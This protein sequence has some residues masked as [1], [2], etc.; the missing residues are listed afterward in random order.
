MR[1]LK[2][3]W[4][5]QTG[6]VLAGLF[7]AASTGLGALVLDSPTEIA[8]AGIGTFLVVASGYLV[9]DW[10][11]SRPRR[12]LDRAAAPVPVEP[13]TP[14]V[15]N[16]AVTA[17]RVEV[18]A[19]VAP[20]AEPPPPI[21]ASP[22]DEVV[23]DVAVLFIHGLSSSTETWAAFERLIGQ[24]RDLRSLDLIQFGY[25]TGVSTFRP[26]TRIPDLDTIAARLRT[27]FENLEG[28][29]RAVVIVTHSMGGLVVQNFLASMLTAGQGERLSRIRRIVMFACPNAGSELFRTI[30]GLVPMRHPQEQ[31]LRPL[32]AQIT[33]IQQVILNQ[34]VH[35]SAVT[36]RTCPIPL[37]LY[38]GETDNVVTPQSAL[39]VFPFE[40]TGVVSGNHNTIIQPDSTV[41]ESYQALKADLK[42]ALAD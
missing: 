21:P 8:V 2:E 22:P 16:P 36:D 15:E 5:K 25:R 31:Q 29:Y 32:N 42:A 6:L 28:T 23:R 14:Q 30:R 33:K 9:A 13:L 40:Q 27:R 10:A 12:K 7:G 39:N 19:L 3:L 11:Q 1:K 4:R 35:A 26:D 17:P 38:A 24:D 18:P 37:R 20:P 41:H 34:V